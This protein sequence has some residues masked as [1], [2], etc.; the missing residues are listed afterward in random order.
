[1]TWA[2]RHTLGLMDRPEI[3]RHW[4]LDPTITFLNHGTFG[5]C[6]RPVLD[7]QQQLRDE[8]ER[9]PLI[10]LDDQLDARLDAARQPLAA[11]VG[12]RPQDI[13]FAP[14]AT[15][16]VNA[17]LRSL[18]F[19][20]GDEILTTDH[21]YNACVNT[22]RHVARAAGARVV[23]ASIPF[24]LTSADEVVDAIVAAAT[25]RTKLAMFSHVTSP[26][27]LVLPVE[28]IAAALHERG[29]QS[30]VD[31]AHAP[32]MVPISLDELGRQGVAYYTGNTHKWLCGPKGGGF[33]WVRADVQLGIHP[34]VLSH[35][36][37]SSRTD[38]TYFNEAFDWPGTADITPYLTVPAALEFLAG[39]LPGGWPALMDANHDL[40]IR[41]RDLLLDD[42]GTKPLA[43]TDMI[44]SMAA[45][46]LPPDIL[47][48]APELPPNAPVGSTLPLDPLHALLLE[49]QRIEVPVYPWPPVPTHYR[50]TLRLLRVSAQAYNGLA[51]Y[52]RLAQALRELVATPVG[53]H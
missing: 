47:P 10:F 27:A 39:L 40:A 19:E 46:E 31:G 6:P 36:L 49:Q 5:A 45:V 8:M 12:A 35:A 42:L 23:V 20:P 21:E 53:G 52:A 1:M 15:T 9:E 14:N 38:R 43:P 34:P 25:P 4:L 22:A 41:A 2:T 30:L 33:L 50:T 51:D 24:P 13:G 16:G 7:Y 28:R 44:G 18:Q 48:P 26:T 11:L 29:I 3:A 37:N 17:V 32:G